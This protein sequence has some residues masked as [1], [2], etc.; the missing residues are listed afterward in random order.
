[1][2]LLETVVLL[3]VMQVVPEKFNL[4]E[5]C[6]LPFGGISSKNMLAA[7]SEFASDAGAGKS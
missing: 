1:M 3:H 2:T 5:K 4:I 6:I 7:F